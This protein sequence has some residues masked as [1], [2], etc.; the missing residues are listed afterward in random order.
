MATESR[1]RRI[2]REVIAT[3]LAALPVTATLKEKR[4]AVRNAY[5]FGTRE[6]HPYKMWCKEVQEALGKRGAKEPSGVVRVDPFTRS[7]QCSW[8]NNKK[9]LSCLAARQLLE[10]H[11]DAIDWQSWQDWEHHLE[12]FPDE[13]EL[14]QAQY[15]DWLEENGLSTVAGV[16][17]RG[18]RA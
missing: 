18:D 9:C 12:A 11:Q 17:R 7:V 13:R 4:K 1:W 2:S 6:H 16:V 14:I 3:V 15:A 10:Q 5:P 8:C